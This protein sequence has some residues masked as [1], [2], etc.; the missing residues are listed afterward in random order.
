MIF[1]FAVGFL[2]ACPQP[3]RPAAEFITGYRT[4]NRIDVEVL[5]GDATIHLEANGWLRRFTRVY[6]WILSTRVQCDDTLLPRI[7]FAPSQVRASLD[8]FELEPWDMDWP[9]P[10]VRATAEPG[11]Y[12]LAFRSELPDSL[13][14][15]L[16]RRKSIIMIE[17]NDFMLLDGQPVHI[18]PVRA[19]DPDLPEG[20]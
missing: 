10:E 18:E 7:Q 19:L 17:F 20:R 4:S 1:A 6:E 8:G 5:K 2:A 3:P 9:E 11:Q 15:T 13:Y 16:D 14:H 12:W